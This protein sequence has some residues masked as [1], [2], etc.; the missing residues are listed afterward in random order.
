MNT[1]NILLSALSLI[2]AASSAVSNDGKEINIINNKE[3]VKII[4]TDTQ[5][6]KK[7]V[8][9][10]NH[11]SDLSYN[12]PKPGNNDTT[13]DSTNI[14]IKDNLNYVLKLG[15]CD[16][17]AEFE[18]KIKEGTED[19]PY[20]Y[21]KFETGDATVATKVFDTKLASD[22]KKFASEVIGDAKV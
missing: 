3:E 7:G 17:K 12:I 11:N 18:V 14:V 16:Q 22:L 9:N 5:S 21:P 20:L 6:D 13:S 2:S 8:E 19:L 10:K 1:F 4:G 15:T